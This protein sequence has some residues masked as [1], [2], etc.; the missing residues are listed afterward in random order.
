M[1]EMTNEVRKKI[2]RYRKNCLDISE[3]IKG[4]KLKDEDLHDCIIKD[5]APK[6]RDLRNINL[7][8]C[9]IGGEGI[10]TQICDKDFRGGI[11][12][13]TKFLGRTFARRNDFRNCNFQSAELPYVEYQ[14]SDLRDS[15]FCEVLIR[16]GT[17]YGYKSKIDGGIFQDLG[18]DWGVE[19]KIDG[20]VI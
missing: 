17:A 9:K 10:I 7:S 18:K 8:G 2:A 1:K 11:F 4:Y 6:E 15:N 20:E 5:F 14:Y 19:I 12:I 3:L 13:K 16:L